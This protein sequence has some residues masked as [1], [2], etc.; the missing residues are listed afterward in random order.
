MNKK[1]RTEKDSL[2]E[3]QVPIDAW[4]GVQSAR[5][6]ANFPISG[7]PPDR[8]FIIAHVR[9]KRAAACANHAA[10]W[11]EERLRH[12]IVAAADEIIAGKYHD[13]F[14]VDRFQAGAGTSHNMNSNEVL[15]NL[16]NVALGGAKGSYKPIHPNGYTL[17]RVGEIAPTRFRCPGD[18]DRIPRYRRARRTHH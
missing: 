14:V 12:A 11:L 9:V 16:A 10:G 1:F 6:M 2:G 15:A 17:G 4:Y 5:A 18:G 8:D 13:Q 7:R 3:Y